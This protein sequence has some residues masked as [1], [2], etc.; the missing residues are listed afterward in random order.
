MQNLK[1]FEKIELCIIFVKRNKMGTIEL[2]ANLHDLIENIDDK[3]VLNAIYIL[4]TKQLKIKPKADFWD[5]L[6]ENVKNDI[7]EAIKEADLGKV[8]THESVVEEIKAKYNI[9]L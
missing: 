3:N 7:E 1:L 6:P 9:Q 8:Y 4:L 5:E 2:K